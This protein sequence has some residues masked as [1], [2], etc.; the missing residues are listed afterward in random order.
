MA[1][2][3]AFIVMLVFGAAA[4]ALAPLAFTLID[5]RNDILIPSQVFFA[6]AAFLCYLWMKR[7]YGRERTMAE[8][9]ASADS[10]AIQ[11][12]VAQPEPAP[13]PASA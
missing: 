3:L 6:P 2:R 9:W 11:A 1:A 13:E 8:F 12:P 4:P 10:G 5:F 7:R